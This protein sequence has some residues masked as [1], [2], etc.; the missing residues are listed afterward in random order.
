[1]SVVLPVLAI[2]MKKWSFVFWL[3]V[4]LTV[5]DT[6][7]VSTAYSTSFLYSAG[8]VMDLTYWKII[9]EHK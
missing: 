4:L 6:T 7:V 3:L 5:F 2:I 8:M 1:M 9:A